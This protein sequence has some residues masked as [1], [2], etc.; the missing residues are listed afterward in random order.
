MTLPRPLRVAIQ[1]ERGSFSEEAAE[2]LLGQALKFVHAPDTPHLFSRVNRH[3]AHV[4]L[5]PIET[6]ENGP[7]YPNWDL[8]LQHDLLV[9][10]EAYLHL[11]H[12][13]IAP[14]GTFLE[15]VRRVYSHPIALGQCREF[16]RNHDRLEAIS[17]HDTAG[18]VQMIVS[19]R[20]TDAAAIAGRSAAEHYAAKVLR[21]GIEDDASNYARFF[22][23]ARESTVAEECEELD[24]R[25]GES[26]G[27]K[28]S[29]VFCLDDEPGVLYESLHAFASREVG[30]AK[31]DTRPVRGTPPESLFYLDFHG[32]RDDDACR[33][34]LAELERRAGFVRVFGSYPAGEYDW[35]GEDAP[36]LPRS[37]EERVSPSIER[38]SGSERRREESD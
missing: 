21:E 32:N 7:I 37:R 1:G 23:L 14:V 13:L 11:H 35:L 26:R 17:T 33:D 36:L 22:L 16:F 25:I 2:R 10:G 19:E 6:S 5:L 34:A 20:R 8:M 28:T 27:R 30:I 38:R 4:A 24:D 31:L 12:C 15:D 29:I 18:S 3:D 9:C